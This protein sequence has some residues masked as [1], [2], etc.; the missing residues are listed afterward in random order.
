MTLLLVMSTTFTYVAALILEQ[1]RSERIRRALVVLLVTT[2]IAILTIF[3]VPREVQDVIR[4]AISH[5]FLNLAMPLGISYYTFKLLSYFIDVY[6]GTTKAEKRFIP[7]L[8]YV[9][10][11]PQMV[12]GPIQRSETFLPQ[13][14]G[15]P[16]ANFR[17][18]LL[19]VQRIL[20]GFFKKFVAA[21]NLGILVNFVFTHMYATGTP[22]LL[23]FYGF[24]LQ[25][26]ADFSGL[27][28]IAIGAAWL[29]G[30]ASPEN[31]NAPFAAVN[32]SEYWRRW[33]I[34]LTKWLTDYV[35]TPLR[36]TVRQFGNFGLLFSLFV[37][38]VLIGL[39][40]GVRWT[41]VVFGALHAI[42]LS[43]DALTA[44]SRKRYYKEY[45]RADRITNKLGPVVTFHLVVFALLFFRVESVGDGFYYVGHLFSG[46]RAVSPEFRTYCYHL[47][48]P[49]LAGF[50][51][52]GL[53]EVGDYFRRRNETGE[54][55]LIL[56]R[57]AR[58]SVYTS[59]VTSSLVLLV[60]VYLAGASSSP[61]LYA[62][63]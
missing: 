56:P 31:F 62:I 18:V 46:L 57:W 44:R 13:I 10:F 9:T 22:L 63:F 42:Y 21:N 48:L 40:H 14:E 27:A 47:G 8:A 4:N 49:M 19:G 50:W 55:V 61:F 28:D 34:T 58:W 33:H 1:A 37:N 41:Y 53:A 32:I 52:Y 45:P 6:W 23:G 20:L 29:L 2:L 59:T 43:I 5:P 38:M 15:A 25:L 54:L 7:F 35:F 30:I 3:K 51:A 12:A 16:R 36:M 17:V 60:L 26:Y 24:T 39:W 11:F